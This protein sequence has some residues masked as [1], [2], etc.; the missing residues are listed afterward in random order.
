MH[1]PKTAIM[2]R[3]PQIFRSGSLLQNVVFAI[4][5]VDSY[6][7]SEV[8][9]TLLPR[10][11]PPHYSQCL[12]GP[13]L[14]R[15]PPM[16][17]TLRPTALYSRCPSND[18]PLHRPHRPHRD[19]RFGRNFRL[20]EAKTYMKSLSCRAAEKSCNDAPLESSSTS[21]PSSESDF[22]SSSSKS[23]SAKP[24]LVHSY[25]VSSAEIE[26]GARDLHFSNTECRP[27]SVLASSFACVIVNVVNESVGSG[28]G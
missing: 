2:H 9:A 1:L 18:Y 11:G 15:Y 24:Y 26:G 10:L 27:V 19:N 25:G 28:P 17:S 21:S 4:C 8:N 3:P 14:S 6:C 22:S 7:Y 23:S 12:R 13:R 5:R 16:S 20:R